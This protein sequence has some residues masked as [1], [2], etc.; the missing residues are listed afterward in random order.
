ME[1]NGCEFHPELFYDDEFQI[2]VRRE[3]DDTLT[4]E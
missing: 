2:W 4:V 3:D 1:C